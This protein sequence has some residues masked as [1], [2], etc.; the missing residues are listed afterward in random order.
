MDANDLSSLPSGIFD[1]LTALEKL[2]LGHN[3]L[4][5]LPS[6][7]F[8]KLTALTHPLVGYTTILVHCYQIYLTNS[9]R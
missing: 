2:G 6:G 9:L 5:S 1:E 3:D 4:S 7:I 8:D